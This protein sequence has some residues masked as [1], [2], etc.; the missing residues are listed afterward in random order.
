MNLH[1]FRRIEMIRWPWPAERKPVRVE[2]VRYVNEPAR[3]A[4]RAKARQMYLDQGKDVPA[5][6]RP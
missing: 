2:H 1:R 3:D 6:L 5:V 4:I